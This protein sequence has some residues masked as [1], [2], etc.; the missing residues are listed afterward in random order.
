M[1]CNILKD[2]PRKPLPELLSFIVDNRGKS[3]PTS[4]DG[5]HILIATNCIRNENLY[6][7]YEKVRYFSD[8]VYE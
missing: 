6:P 1:G 3:V 2:Y 8:D 5:T 7:T 4:E